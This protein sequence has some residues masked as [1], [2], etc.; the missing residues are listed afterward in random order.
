V[1]SAAGNVLTAEEFIDQ[2]AGGAFSAAWI[3]G[4]CPSPWVSKDLAAAV[5]KIALIIAQDM[6]ENAV[7]GAATLILPA[8]SFAE[9]DGSFMNHAGRIQPFT[10]AID[11]PEGARW[12]GRYLYEIG[13]HAGLF[14]ARKVREMMVEEIEAFGSIH[15]APLLPRNFH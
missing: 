10:R 14:N 4:G 5:A 12:D 7:T 9:R 11:P 8:C 15:E 2:A 3:T 1:Q 6:F 13:G